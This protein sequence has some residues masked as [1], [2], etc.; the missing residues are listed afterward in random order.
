MSARE[1]QYDIE[2]KHSVVYVLRCLIEIYLFLT[3]KKFNNFLGGYAN[4]CVCK[5]LK[6]VNNGYR[7]MCYLAY[8]IYDRNISYGFQSL[9]AIYI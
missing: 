4:S 7:C 6:C 5:L 1:L 3:N 8:D 9:N 2:I